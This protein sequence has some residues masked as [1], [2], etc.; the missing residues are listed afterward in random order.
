MNIVTWGA[1]P[2]GQP[3]IEHAAWSLLWWSLAGGLGFALA[4]DLWVR[5]RPRAG[6]E[7]DLAPRVAATVPARI[8]R[9]SLAARLFH[10]LMAAAMLVL[11]A[12]AFAPRLGARFDWIGLHVLAGTVL[13]AA[14]AF[15]IVHVLCCLDFGAIW[16]RWADLAE[17]RALVGPREE[18]ARAARPGKYPLG[19][20]LYHLAVAVLGLTMVATGLAMLSRVRTPFAV[21]DPYRFFGD[22]GWGIV[23]ALHGLAGMALVALVI[24]HVFFALRPEK[25]PIT[26]SM[27]VGT[28]DRDFYLSH[29]DPARWTVG[30]QA[31]GR[32]GAKL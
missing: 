22:G 23:Y 9:H 7:P 4:H 10:W 26:R 1:S 19:N 20:K 29:H 11:L 16:P 21:R 18:G 12:T 8:P 5:L 25:R 31:A 2:W 15:H 6:Q 14:V 13:V 30:D 27:L 28:L 3:V 17:L 32:P 24:I